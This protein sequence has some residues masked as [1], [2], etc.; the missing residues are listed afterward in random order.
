MAK[1]ILIHGAWHG[2][3]CWERIIPLLE[4]QGHSV[5]APDL[6]GMGKDST[7]LDTITLDYWAQF[8]ADLV[9]QQA[10]PVLLLG[11]SRGGIVI[12]QA[13]EYASAHIQ[14]LIYL[15][16]FLVPNGATL[17]DMVRTYNP[18]PEAQQNKYILSADKKF[19]TT[20]PE[21]IPNLFYNTTPE[22]WANR[23][24]SQVS[25]EPMVVSST[26]L[27]LSEQYFGSVPRIYIECRQDK[28]VPIAL[29]R[30]MISALP[31]QEVLS[32]DTDHSPFYSAPELLVQKL[33]H[34][35]TGSHS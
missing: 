5:L 8:V 28:A 31:C 30:A 9:R 16:A 24:A 3:W 15:S 13:A 27:K 7:P 29:Q 14:K 33:L 10:E 21:A 17:V 6:P 35:A 12:S 4:Q 32:L 26:P 11:H 25:Q 34:C 22:C 1:F 18:N 20:I 19:S 23:A 2:S